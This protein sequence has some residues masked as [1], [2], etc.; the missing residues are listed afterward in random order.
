MAIKSRFR[1]AERTALQPRLIASISGLEK[2]GKTHFALGAPGP[3]AMFNI[4][5]GLEGVVGKFVDD[6]DIQVMDIELSQEPEKALDEWEAVKTA[7]MNKLRDPN[8]RTIIWDTATEMW[9][10]VRIARFGKLVQV[11]PF[12]YGP[13]NAEFSKLL[14][15]AYDTNKNLI[16]LNRMK[17]V[18]INDKR[19]KDYERAGFSGTGFLAQVNAQVYRDES[20]ED[21]PGEFHCYVK[22]CRQNPDLAGEVLSGEMCSWQ[23]LASMV[24]E[25]TS[26]EDWE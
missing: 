20:D 11:M 17:A 6:K 21:G 5:I 10:L 23:W 12:H 1:T 15:A 13:V 3:V 24:V 26:P 16:L 8:V 19:T 9:E 4:D 18:Y 2:Q 7:Y 14:K 22:D 25:G